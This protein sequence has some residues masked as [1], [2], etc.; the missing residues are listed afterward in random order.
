ML[1]SEYLGGLCQNAF[2]ISCFFQLYKFLT[3]SILP[4]VTVLPLPY[5]LAAA[6]GPRQ[7]V[8]DRPR[9]TSRIS[10]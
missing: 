9:V 6:A 3:T 7:A 4:D 5:P 8:V 2:L 10:T 1:S